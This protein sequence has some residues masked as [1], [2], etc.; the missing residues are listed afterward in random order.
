MPAQKEKRTAA[1]KEKSSTRLQALMPLATAARM[2]YARATGRTTDDVQILGNVARLIATRTRVFV[3]S[4][5]ETA[6]ALPADLLAAGRFEGGGDSLC[7][8][9]S[10]RAPIGSLAI[11]RVDLWDA[12]EDVR[13]A[14]GAGSWTMLDEKKEPPALQPLIPLAKAAQL[15]YAAAAQGAEAAEDKLNNVARA[16]ATRFGV[17]ECGPGKSCGPTPNLLMPDEIIE[18][19]F[20]GGGLT[21]SFRD[22][23]PNLRNLCIRTA[24]LGRAI[25]EVSHLFKSKVQGRA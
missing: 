1:V 8:D 7:F 6:R 25:A 13:K 9:D 10:S 12:E 21:L 3:L 14:Y 4:I 18:G 23:R 15:A 17:F 22:G 19:D 24:D 5:D 20:G 16:I 11:R 2:L